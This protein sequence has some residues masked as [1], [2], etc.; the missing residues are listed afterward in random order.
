MSKNRK[1][2]KKI[3]EILKAILTNIGSVL[4]ILGLCTVVIAIILNWESVMGEIQRFIK[5]IM[6][7]IFG[8]V[9]AFLINPLVESVK[10]VL[11][12]VIFKTNH[13]KACKYTSVAL[14]Y[15]ILIGILAITMVYIIPQIT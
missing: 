5:I 1:I 7:F 11:E 12:K 3:S 14:S 8:L 10:K 15:I 9:L 13:K 2:C 6:P 4:L